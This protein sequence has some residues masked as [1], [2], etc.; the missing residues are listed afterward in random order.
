MI[1]QDMSS[2]VAKLDAVL[3]AISLLIALF[4][5]LFIFNPSGTTA[6]L[7]P[8]AT[9]VL[10]FSFGELIKTG[11]SALKVADTAGSLWQLR[12]E[13]FRGSPRLGADFRSL[14]DSHSLQSMLFIFSIHPYDVGDLVFIGACMRSLF[15]LL[16]FAEAHGHRRP[17]FGRAGVW[18]LLDNLQA[19]RWSG[20]GR[21]KYANPLEASWR[22]LM[23]GS[24]TRCWARRSTSSTSPDLRPCGKS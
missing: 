19:R 11:E 17:A 9:I 21:A 4:I 22:L 2:A 18:S 14:A 5:W 3:L 7:V 23:F 8:I 20:H 1:S 15:G 10:G 16:F 6:E 24:Q 13:S 12:Q